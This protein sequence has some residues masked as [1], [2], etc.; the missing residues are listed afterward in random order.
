[1]VQRHKYATRN[2]TGGESEK[3][4]FE[5]GYCNDARCHA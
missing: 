1:M 3:K 5:D 2:H 4:G